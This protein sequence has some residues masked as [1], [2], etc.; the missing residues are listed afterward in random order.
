MGELY[1]MNYI[2]IVVVLDSHPLLSYNLSRS[3]GVSAEDL[4]E[5]DVH[6]GN[7]HR[8]TTLKSPEF[9]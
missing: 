9:Y 7:I 3:G 8:K 5:K 2:Q 1:C 6:G 4:I